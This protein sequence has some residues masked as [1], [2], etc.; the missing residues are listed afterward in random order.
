[1]SK[2]KL[3][4]CLRMVLAPQAPNEDDLLDEAFLELNQ[5]SSDLYGLI[6]SRYILKPRGIA[7]MH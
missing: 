7:K 1:M 3:R 5:E 2:E 4:T 6:H